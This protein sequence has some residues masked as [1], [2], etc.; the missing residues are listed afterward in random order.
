MI[1]GSTALTCAQV[2]LMCQL[3]HPNIVAAEDIY[4]PSDIPAER[5]D[6]SL[7]GFLQMQRSKEDHICVRMPY[8]PADMAWLIH[9]CT[10]VLTSEHVQVMRARVTRHCAASTQSPLYVVTLPCSSFVCR[11]CA[12]FGVVPTL[13]MPLAAPPSPRRILDCLQLAPTITVELVVVQVLARCRGD[14]QRSEAVKHVSY[15]CLHTVTC[16]S[17]E[18]RILRPCA[19]RDLYHTRIARVPV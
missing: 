11:F 10:Q 17:L 13:P 7:S 4:L 2:L 14:S 1:H 19:K 18:H 8:Y 16:S 3:Q 9:S 15:A 5:R 12:A 6:S